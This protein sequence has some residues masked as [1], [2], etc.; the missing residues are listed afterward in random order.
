MNGYVTHSIKYGAFTELLF[1]ECVFTKL[2][3]QL[4]EYPGPNSM[5]LI[6]N[7]QFHHNKALL[8]FIS[9]RGSILIFYHLIGLN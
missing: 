5:L 7:V 1:N 6:D 3:K 2:E 9:Q 4:N 8:D